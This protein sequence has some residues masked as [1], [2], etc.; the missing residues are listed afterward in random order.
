MVPYGHWH[1]R[2]ME[3]FV[4][5]LGLT[6]LEAIRCATSEGSLALRLDGKVGRIEAGCEAD[7]MVLDGNPAQDVSL[8]GEIE[9]IRHVII[10]GELQDLSPLPSRQP[11]PGWR[12]G[13]IG[14]Q[15]TRDVAFG[16]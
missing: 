11:L 3:V 6:P 2:E 14:N 7:L 9:R 10:R 8:L 13:T 15:L 16:D 5:H 1:Y 12:V 4:N